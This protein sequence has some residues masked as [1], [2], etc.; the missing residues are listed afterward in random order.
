M[1][2]LRMEGS[3]STLKKYFNNQNSGWKFQSL[4]LLGYAIA[5]EIMDKLRDLS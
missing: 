4:T 1:S 3:T 5:W 2:T